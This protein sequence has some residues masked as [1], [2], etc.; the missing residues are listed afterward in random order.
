MKSW[1]IVCAV[2]LV[3][4]GCGG[5]EVSNEADP[6]FTASA[7]HGIAASDISNWNTAY[8]WGNHATA[9]YLK[10]ESDPQYAASPA[11]GI[12]STDI[13]NWNTAYSWGNH[14]TAGYQAR[15]SGTCPAGTAMN[16]ISST[17]GVTCQNIPSYTAGSGLQLSGNQFSVAANGI[18]GTMVATGAIAVPQLSTFTAGIVSST[19]DVAV[20]SHY[21]ALTSGISTVRVAI[22]TGGLGCSANGCGAGVVTIQVNGSTVTQFGVGGDGSSPWTY[23]TGS[24]G[25]GGG[26]TIQVLVHANSPTAPVW[27]RDLTMEWG[28]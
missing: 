21:M 2:A 11:H 17:G 3:A 18:T 6:V 20:R 28:H 4:V 24:F 15:V 27:I 14:A 7:A 26:S 5:G 16:V 1:R 9:G 25:F 22:S 23:L 12:A 13:S 10:T 19:T 8:G